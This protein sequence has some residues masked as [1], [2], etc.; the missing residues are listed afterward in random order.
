MARANI[1]YCEIGSRIVVMDTRRDVYLQLPRSVGEALHDLRMGRAVASERSESLATLA[2]IGLCDDD[3]RRP[4][5]PARVRVPERDT[6]LLAASPPGRLMGRTGLALALIACARLAVRL[7]PLRVLVARVRHLQSRPSRH[8]GP[9]EVEG[10]VAAFQLAQ[11]L[12]PARGACLPDALALVHLLRER[13]ISCTMVFG[14]RLEPF[15]AHCWVQDEDRILCD[16]YER[17]ACFTPILEL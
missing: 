13:G 3:F 10:C 7:L 9:G 8:A 5:E 2:R 1:S 12:L 15:E 14:V 16:T 6:L 17:A 4:A 11:R